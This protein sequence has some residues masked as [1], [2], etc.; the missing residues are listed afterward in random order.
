MICNAQY[1]IE[2]LI[3]ELGIPREREIFRD[4]NARYYLDK[5]HEENSFDETEKLERGL[6]GVA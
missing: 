6:A 4:L 2:S 5:N 3:M 1:L